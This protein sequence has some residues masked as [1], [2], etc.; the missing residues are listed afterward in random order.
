METIMGC[1]RVKCKKKLLYK[2]ICFDTISI[3]FVTAA[4]YVF[5]IISFFNEDFSELGITTPEKES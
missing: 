4:K 2:K 5:F 3:I 1:E